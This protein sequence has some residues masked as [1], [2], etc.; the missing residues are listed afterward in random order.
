MFNV[1]ISGIRCRLSLLFPAVLLYLV[2][3][4]PSGIVLF[5]FLASCIHECGHLFAAYLLNCPPKELVISC[6]GM[7]MV[8]E[9]SGNYSVLTDILIALAGPMI[10][11]LSFFILYCLPVAPIYSTVHLVMAMFNLLPVFPLDGGRALACWFEHC[12]ETE[13]GE[14]LEKIVFI[15]TII[16]LLCLGGLLAFQPY[17]NMTLM[18]VTI[19]LIFIRLFYNGN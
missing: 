18:I 11:I 9:P 12:F 8:T 2:Y 10:N 15:L 5:G 1:T 19:Y 13:F 7:R 6:F 4:D 16:P 3:V 17:Y 14:Q